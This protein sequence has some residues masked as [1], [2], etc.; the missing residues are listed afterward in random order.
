MDVTKDMRFASRL[1]MLLSAVGLAAAAYIPI[2]A[3][4]APLFT[5]DYSPIYGSTENTG[6]SARATFSFSDVSGDVL[7]TIGITNTTN[8]T[9]GL[10]ATEATLVGLTFDFPTSD[11]FVYSGGSVFPTLYQDAS[12]QPYGTFDVC[13]RSTTSGGNCQ[14]GNPTTGLTA[15]QSTTVTFQFDTALTAAQLGNLF[16]T[17]YLDEAGGYDTAARFQQVNAGGGSDKVIGRD[18]PVEEIPEP[19]SLA[20]LGA[21]IAG[22]T[23]ARRK[24]ATRA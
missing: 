23:F 22:L 19:A 12:L 18:P 9:L 21:A 6:A 2:P 5:V 10:G 11:S 16:F 20:L 4:A 1:K 15:G 24:G 8:G 17:D 7:L 14:G 13:I 3:Q